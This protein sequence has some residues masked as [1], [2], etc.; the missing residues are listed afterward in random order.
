MAANALALECSSRRL[1][2]EWAGCGCGEESEREIGPSGKSRVFALAI[3]LEIKRI[4]VFPC[5]D[6]TAYHE[7]NFSDCV[8]QLQQ[9][10]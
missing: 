1:A 10:R 8:E 5:S 2:A 3:E 4:L 7:D 6:S 9:S